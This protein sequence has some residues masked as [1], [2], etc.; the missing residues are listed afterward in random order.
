MIAKNYIKYP[1]ALRFQCEMF[2]NGYHNSPRI[3]RLVEV[4]F[5]WT[6]TI[7]AWFTSARTKAK[8]L[9]KAWKKMQSEMFDKRGQVVT[10]EAPMDPIKALILSAEHCGVCLRNTSPAIGHSWTNNSQEYRSFCSMAWDG[11]PSH[12][13]W[14]RLEG[15]RE[16]SAYWGGSVSEDRYAN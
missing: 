9:V 12:A 6:P 15:H 10:P 4:I 2:S 3:M 8:Q 5:S 1:E 14:G 7:P 11:A 13:K 16:Y